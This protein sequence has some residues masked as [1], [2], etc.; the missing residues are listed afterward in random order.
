LRFFTADDASFI[1]G[2]EINCSGGRRIYLA[3]AWAA[4]P[5]AFLTG[6]Q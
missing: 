3:A 5:R 1:I 6:L 2:Q 4:M